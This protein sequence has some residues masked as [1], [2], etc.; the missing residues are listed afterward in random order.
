MEKEPYNG[1]SRGNTP[2]THKLIQHN[3]SFL[4]QIVAPDPQIELDLLLFEKKKS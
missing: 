1:Q 4:T 3:P 2:K